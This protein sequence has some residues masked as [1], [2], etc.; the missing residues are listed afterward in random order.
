MFSEADGVIVPLHLDKFG[1]LNRLVAWLV[2]CRQS[3]NEY[4]EA[5]YAAIVKH[6][7]VGYSASFIKC[8]YVLWLCSTSEAGFCNGMSLQNGIYVAL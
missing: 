6:K 4:R 1:L 3:V 7:K 8:F 5:L 2:V